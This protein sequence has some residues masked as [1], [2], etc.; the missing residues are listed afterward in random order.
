M[1]VELCN[2]T[3]LYACAERRALVSTVEVIIYL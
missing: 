3:W 1:K 2:A